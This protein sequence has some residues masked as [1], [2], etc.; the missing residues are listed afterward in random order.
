MFSLQSNIFL[1]G[2]LPC[3]FKY[4]AVLAKKQNYSENYLPYMGRQSLAFV[5][6]FRR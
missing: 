2:K 5:A 1:C 6:K 4:N 3:L